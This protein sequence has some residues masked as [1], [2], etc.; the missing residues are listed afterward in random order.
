MPKEKKMLMPLSY[1]GLIRY[2]EEGKEKIKLKPKHLVAL[3]VA[4]VLFE[5]F[6]RFL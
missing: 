3:V 4:V 2:P 6:L 1:G 5:I